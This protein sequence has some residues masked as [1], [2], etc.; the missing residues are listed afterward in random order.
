M[1]AHTCE[2]S[3]RVFGHMKRR[4]KPYLNQ[5]ID[6][7]WVTRGEA[8][9]DYQDFP[10]RMP[11]HVPLEKHKKWLRQ[12]YSTGSP[13]INEKWRTHLRVCM[14]RLRELYKDGSPIHTVST[15]FFRAAMCFFGFPDGKELNLIISDWG[16][17]LYTGFSWINGK[18]M[19]TSKGKW[20]ASN[21]EMQ[22]ILWPH[23]MKL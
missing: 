15:A 22:N 14:A 13:S 7:G 3:R 2:P 4:V 16:Y 1:S 11:R 19:R 8:A 17:I 9:E 20:K 23:N 6:V 12:W 10:A 18:L 5:L 21:G